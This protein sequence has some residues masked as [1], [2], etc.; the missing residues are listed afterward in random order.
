MT[1]KELGPVP[2]CEALGGRGDRPG[3]VEGKEGGSE[4][5]TDKK[6][7]LRLNEGSRD[8]CN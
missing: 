4:C 3:A 6:W 7:V 8:L 5:V 2:A 1:A